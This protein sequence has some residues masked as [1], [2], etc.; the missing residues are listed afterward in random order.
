[1]LS[2]ENAYAHKD[3]PQESSPRYLKIFGRTVL[4]TDSH[5]QTS[6]GMG[7]GKS[8]PADMQDEIFVQAL[9]M[10]FLPVKSITGDTECVWGNFP[11]VT[12]GALPFMQCQKETSNQVKDSS[13]API[14]WWNEGLPVPFLPFHKVDPSK[15]YVDSDLGEVQYKVQKEGS[16]T[17]SNTGTV[18]DGVIG[19]KC[20]EAET[21]SRPISLGNENQDGDLVFQLRPSEISAFSELR[22]SPEKCV[23]GFVPYRRCMA[24]DDIQSSTITGH[25]GDEKRI[26]L[27]L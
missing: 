9:P 20:S 5:G 13:A 27:Y 12:H 25:E 2:K 23:K 21:Q 17:D 15:A 8:I 7:T 22:K 3:T 4:V 10:N 6:G 14:P 24:E 18:N 11:H 1:M 19:D 16:C 26:R